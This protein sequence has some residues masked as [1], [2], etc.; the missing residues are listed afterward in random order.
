[1]EEIS[2]DDYQSRGKYQN[3]SPIFSDIEPK[4]HEE[5]KQ[6]EEAYYK[7]MEEK[8]LIPQTSKSGVI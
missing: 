7:V 8:K 1:V 5:L 6:T 2:S 3:E 4:K